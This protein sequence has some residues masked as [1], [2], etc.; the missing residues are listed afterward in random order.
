MTLPSQGRIGPVF[1]AADGSIW[2]NQQFDGIVRWDRVTGQKQIWG[3]SNGFEGFVPIPSRFI[4][5][6]DGDIWIGIGAGVYRLHNGTW[7]TSPF[8]D[9]DTTRSVAG[10]PTASMGKFR[11][12]EG[13]YRV[14]DLLVD[15][16][17][18]V[19]SAFNRAGVAKWDGTKWNKIGDFE[20]PAGPMVLYEDSAG[21]I[22]IGSLQRG[23]GKYNNGMLTMFPK[24]NIVSF[25]E[26]PDRWLFGGGSDGLFLY[27]PQSDQWKPYP[28]NQ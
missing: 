24:L 23:V 9:E 28:S 3:V 5:T 26:T 12:D 8:P 21:A 17:G 1:E 20:F 18:N 14:I 7:E 6:P 15:R 27:D 13:D 16:S 11:R 2:Y 10:M 19:W 4:Q 25:A 22:W